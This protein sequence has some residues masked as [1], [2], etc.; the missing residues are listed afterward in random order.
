MVKQRKQFS[1]IGS[2]H[3]YID[4]MDILPLGH[5]VLGRFGGNSAAGQSKN[6][7]GC[8]IWLEDKEDWEFVMVLDAHN[9]AQSAE[10][11]ISQVENHKKQIASLLSGKV[12]VSLFKGIE[13]VLL[14]LFQEDSFKEDC[15]QVQG[16]TACLIV[17]RKGK[18]LYWFS[19]GDCLLYLFHPELAAFG[20][21]QLNQR[22]FYEWVGQVNTFAQEAPCY[23]SGTRELRQGEN[24]IL[25]TTDGL[26]ECP[27]GIFAEPESIW[28]ECKDTDTAAGVAGLLAK[29]QKNHV[30]DSTTVVFW[31]VNIDQ[32]AAYAS[33]Q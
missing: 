20:Q 32:A 6:E 8:L 29:I 13:N 23:S 16:E 15:R 28:Q 10:L 12:S 25:L 3:T 21:Y 17:V 30:R 26:V 24:Q 9:S 19:V 14:Q 2:E 4:Q 1:W 31:K 33:N 18:Y 5:M 27:G 11:V 7:D 22:H